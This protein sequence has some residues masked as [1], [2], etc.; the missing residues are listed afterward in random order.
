MAPPRSDG[1]PLAFDLIG[2]TK[3]DDT[4]FSGFGR[5]WKVLKVP[6]LSGKLRGPDLKPNLG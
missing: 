5:I 2:K 3:D 6:E 4:I 1:L